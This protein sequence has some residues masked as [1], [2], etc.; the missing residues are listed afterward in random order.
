MIDPEISNKKNNERGATAILLAV[1]LVALIGFG[2]LAVDIG[3]GLVV[4]SELQNVSDA[5]ALAGVRQ[6]AQIYKAPGGTSK[7]MAAMSS[8]DLA[9]VRTKAQEYAALNKGGGISISV[10]DGDVVLGK[11]TPAT[12]AITSTTT[13]VRLVQVTSRRDDN[14]N[15]TVATG[16][17]RVLGINE[18]N[19]SARSAAALTPLNTLNYGQGDFPIGISK[20]WFNS[21]KCNDADTIVVFPTSSASCAGWHVFTEPVF[22]ASKL[23]KVVDG[24]KDGSF[25]TP[26]TI[27]GETYYQF[28]GGTVESKCSNLLELFDAKKDP[29][30]GKML[31]HIPVYDFSCGNVNGQNLI[32]GFVEAEISNVVCG[33]SVRHLDVNVKCNIVDDSV[34]SGGGA[35]DYGLLSMTASMIN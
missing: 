5:A 13:G 23:G 17:G 1:A 11:Y 30:T 35:N 18:M 2:A 25:K 29:V 33:S 16:L 6:L 12:G 31:A 3:M 20:Q 24:L 19:V 10:P 14:S 34:G 8:G 32:L 21:H 15:G 28:G 9:S 4:R 7:I 26:K 22:S 27:A